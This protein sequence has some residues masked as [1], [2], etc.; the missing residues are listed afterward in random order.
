MLIIKII[1]KAAPKSVYSFTMQPTDTDT[2][3]T[4]NTTLW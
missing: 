3:N 4:Y 1:K 2:S